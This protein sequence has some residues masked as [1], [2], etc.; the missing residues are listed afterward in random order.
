MDEVLALEMKFVFFIPVTANC[1]NFPVPFSIR[2]DVGQGYTGL[3]R[4]CWCFR[5]PCSRSRRSSQERD[6]GRLGDGGHALLFGFLLLD[7]VQL[8]LM[9]SPNFNFTVE[10]R[11]LQLE[12][13]VL[14]LAHH[15]GNT[16]GSLNLTCAP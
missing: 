10:A 11:L 16:L 4:V 3:R 2:N 1:Q 7:V 5:S 14:G 12:H 9:G 8:I 6:S 15:M 13:I